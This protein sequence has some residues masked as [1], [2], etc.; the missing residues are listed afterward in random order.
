MTTSA[1]MTTLTTMD[2]ASSHATPPGNHSLSAAPGSSSAPAAAARV[3]ACHEADHGIE[4]NLFPA[5]QL[6]LDFGIAE[7]TPS[8]VR[9]PTEEALRE[10]NEIQVTELRS[11]EAALAAA[12]VLSRLAVDRSDGSG[13]GHDANCM[14][15]VVARRTR[16]AIPYES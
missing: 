8:I 2:G 5:E 11:S 12:A 10:H 7:C 1:S 14:T 6:S 3:R 9:A 16:Q 4:G 15:S 13:S